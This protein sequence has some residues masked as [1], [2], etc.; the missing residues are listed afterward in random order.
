MKL[1]SILAFLFLSYNMVFCQISNG[2]DTCCLS[3]LTENEI[4][5][6]PPEILSVEYKRLKSTKDKCCEK[7]NSE[8]HLIMS[9]LKEI[10]GKEGTSTKSIIQYMGKPDGNERSV[11]QGT[12][13][14]EKGQKALVYKWRGYHD[15]VYFVYKNGKVKYAD[16]YMAWE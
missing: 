11:S 12:M 8:M 13:K 1:L 9:A 15:F 5:N 4:K 2:T 6:A 7:W 3:N 10:L 14:I 16:W